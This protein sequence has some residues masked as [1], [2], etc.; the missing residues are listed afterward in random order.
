MPIFHQNKLSSSADETWM[1]RQVLPIMHSFYSRY[2]ISPKLISSPKMDS[3]K[4]KCN[5]MKLLRILNVVIVI[6]FTCWLRNE[7][8][9]TVRNFVLACDPRQ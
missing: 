2:G 7:V 5:L 4:H 3:D 6:S 1:D 8:L 9:F